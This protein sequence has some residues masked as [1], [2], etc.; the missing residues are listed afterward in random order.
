[1]KLGLIFVV[2]AGLALIAC[3]G[4]EP[5]PKSELD[6]ISETMAVISGNDDDTQR[7]RF[8]LP[9]FVDRC[10][11]IL[12]V[13]NAGD[14]LAFSYKQQ[15]E[16]GLERGE[17]LLDIS[18]N[19]YFVVSRVHAAAERAEAASPK[20]AELFAMYLVG[21]EEGQSA[22]E[23]KDGV[24]AIASALYRLVELEAPT[25]SPSSVEDE[26][27]R[28]PKLLTVKEPPGIGVSRQ[29]IQ[30]LYEQPDIGFTFESSELA[31]GTPRVIGESPDGFAFL[32]LIGPERD[33]TKATIMVA[34][35]SDDPGAIVMNAA[36]MLGLLK[37]LVPNWSGGGDWLAE[38][39]AVAADE[40]E[41]RTIQGNV[42]ITLTAYKELGMVLLTVESLGGDQSSNENRAGSDASQ[43]A[44]APLRTP[45]PTATVPPS[46]AT[47]RSDD[48]QVMQGPLIPFASMYIQELLPEVSRAELDCIVLTLGTE[49]LIDREKKGDF[50]TQEEGQGVLRCLEHE[51]TLRLFL[52]PLVG[53]TGPL[54]TES[55]VC[56]RVGFEDVDVAEM[57]A[58]FM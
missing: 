11:D 58:I 2:L 14:M 50:L 32:E 9:R 23:A 5:A 42:D 34:M 13:T 41:A 33:I 57:L 53:A 38:H 20:C 28:N 55:S 21:R 40:G 17:G 44:I 24:I 54:S 16:A 56:I 8:L 29:A 30:S 39:F 36:Y 31:D 52:T 46:I 18:N 19:L 49:W 4:D 6:D 3:G 37:N 22:D 35:P 15:S 43:T 10:P 27:G 45:T 47:A 26:E 1:M 25:T 7:F 48:Y 12:S 51:P